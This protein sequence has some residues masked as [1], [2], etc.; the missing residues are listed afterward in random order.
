MRASEYL[1]QIF[2]GI[3]MQ[4]RKCEVTKLLWI[5]KQYFIYLII[6]II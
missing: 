4:I 1:F 5:S 3:Y 2:L 6:I